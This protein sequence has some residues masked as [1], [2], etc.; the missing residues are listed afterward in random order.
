LPFDDVERNRAVLE[1]NL[2]KITQIEFRAEF[3][4]GAGAQFLD[5]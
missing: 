5:F 3:A 1:D 4:A 2:V